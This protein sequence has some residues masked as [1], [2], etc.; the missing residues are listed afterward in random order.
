MATKKSL[1]AAAATNGLF[2]QAEE[3]KTQ[4]K[5]TTI[6]KEK[7]HFSVRMDKETIIRWRCFVEAMGGNMGD[8]TAA[9][10]KRYIVQHKKT[11]QQQQA[12]KTLCDLKLGKD[13]NE[14]EKEG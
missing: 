4:S 7:A 6:E 5:K 8:C 12:Y 3:Q 2:V 11:E 9:A 1:E 14:E 10:L 13:N